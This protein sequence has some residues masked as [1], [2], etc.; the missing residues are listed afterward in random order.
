[1]K[2]GAGRL[3]SVFFSISSL[4]HVPPQRQYPV[5]NTQGRPQ[6][7]VQQHRP[8][9]LCTVTAISQAHMALQS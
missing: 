8:E 7:V 9:C 4:V 1:M 6:T 3:A 5:K 2:L